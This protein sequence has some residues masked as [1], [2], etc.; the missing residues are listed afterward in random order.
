MHNDDASVN[1]DLATLEAELQAALKDLEQIRQAPRELR[2][3]SELEAFEREVAE[4]TDRVAALIVALKMQA[5]LERPEVHSES[6][7]LAQAVGRKRN[8]KVTSKMRHQGRREVE[9]RFARGGVVRLKVSYWSGKRRGRK[10]GGGFYPGL[11]L[12]GVDEPCTPLLASDLAQAGE[13][14][15]VRW[16]RLRPLLA[17]HGVKIDVKTL[18]AVTYALASAGAPSAT[19]SAAELARHGDCSACGRS[20]RMEGGRAFAGRRKAP[21]PGG[22]RHRYSSNWREPKLL[23]I[24]L[25]H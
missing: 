16:L 1:P 10:R 2:K 14:R 21:R 3:A 25:N 11:V 9:V 23:I 7:A 18:R 20:A 5:S 13:R 19:S 15:L 12:L 8:L 24:Y 4:T 22:G 6:A 17:E